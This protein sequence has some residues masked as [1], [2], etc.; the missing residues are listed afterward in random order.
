MPASDIER[1]EAE[2]ARLI[3]QHVAA[4]FFSSFCKALQVCSSD[5]HDSR[6]LEREA[7]AEKCEGG[8]RR[9]MQITWLH[10]VHTHLSFIVVTETSAKQ[11]IERER[12][13]KRTWKATPLV[14]MRNTLLQCAYTHH[15]FIEH[16]AATCLHLS[17][18][19]R[20]DKDISKYVIERD[21]KRSWKLK[22]V[23][24]LRDLLLLFAYCPYFPRKS[25]F[26]TE[27]Q[28]EMFT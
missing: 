1:A 16:T 25:T 11:S 22:L 7:Y 19:R 3:A 14:W 6:K 23:A 17:L 26:P 9:W 21:K 5:E 20:R 13:K 18:I 2:G 28:A 10:C 15:S 27:M 8:L 24:W 4:F 12:E